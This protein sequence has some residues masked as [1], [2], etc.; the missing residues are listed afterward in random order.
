[1]SQRKHNP[2]QSQ[3]S[4]QNP[5]PEDMYR[6][7]DRLFFHKLLHYQ[8]GDDGQS[9]TRKISAKS[10]RKNHSQTSTQPKETR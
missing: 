9:C 10:Q 8:L 2:D 3:V 6:L 4:P 7:A 1:M 5:N